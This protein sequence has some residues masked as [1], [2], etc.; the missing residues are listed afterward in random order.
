[1]DSIMICQDHYTIQLIESQISLQFIYCWNMQSHVT[2]GGKIFIVTYSIP[3]RELSV[4][5]TVEPS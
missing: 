1:M 2:D 3:L 4:I 5:D